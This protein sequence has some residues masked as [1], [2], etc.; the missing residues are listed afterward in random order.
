MKITFIINTLEVGGAAKMIKYVSNIAADCFDEISMIDIYDQNYQDKDL[1]KKISIISLGLK[2]MPRLKRQLALIPVVEK[3]IKNENPDIIFSFIGHVNVISRVATYKLKKI[4]F[5]AAER[6]DPFSQSVLWKI[7]TRWAYEHSD[8]CFFQLEGAR[9]FFSKKVNA[10]SFVIPNPFIPKDY[11]EPFNGDR[12]KTIVSAGR[13]A[14]EKGF[15]LLIEAFAD[16]HKRYPEYQ[17]IIYGDGPLRKQYECLVEKNNLK[18]NKD[19]YFPGYVDSISR[20][21]QKEGIFVL[22][23]LYEGIPNSLIEAMSVGLPCIAT[24][25]SPGGPRFLMHNGERGILVPINNVKEIINAVQT[26]IE[27]KSLAKNYG[28]KAMRVIE[29]LNEIKIRK[30]WQ[31]AFDLISNKLKTNE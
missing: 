4:I 12:N 13:F 24:N 19:V 29:D 18:L 26:I 1:N 31:S 14:K 22:P 11:V 23:S 5:L 7:F 21:I 17:L 28:Q 3:C 8:Y 6:G 20:A 9:D 16:I 27:N 25:C 30:M 10:K 15:G 2:T